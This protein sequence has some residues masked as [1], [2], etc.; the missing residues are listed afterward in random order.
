[1]SSHVETVEWC[2][3]YGLQR[4]DWSG[5]VTALQDVIGLPVYDLSKIMDSAAAWDIMYH[6]RHWPAQRAHEITSLRGIGSGL[7]RMLESTGIFAPHQQHYAAC[8]LYSHCAKYTTRLPFIVPVPID[9]MHSIP[10]MP[11]ALAQ[12]VVAACGDDA[13]TVQICCWL[14]NVI[15]HK[16]TR[17]TL[18]K[19]KVRDARGNSGGRRSLRR[20]SGGKRMSATAR[21]TQDAIN[22][23]LEQI[24]AHSQEHIATMTCTVNSSPPNDILIVLCAHQPSPSCE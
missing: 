24:T 18:L 16:S 7:R 3:N 11:H 22:A 23:A 17:S 13:N 20:Q 21:E 15:V 9:H 2:E 14:K 1:M 8:A 6:A 12:A 5:W 19:V 4:F 10:V